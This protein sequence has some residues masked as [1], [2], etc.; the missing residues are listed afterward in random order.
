ML[1][2][3]TMVLANTLE[4]KDVS[5]GQHSQRLVAMA[6][7]TATELGLDGER[8]G[9][10]RLGACLHDIGKVGVPSAILRKVERLSDE[11]FDVVRAHPEIGAT[12]LEGIDT[13]DEVRQ[14]VRHHHERFDGAGYPH[15]LAGEAIPLG[16]RIVCVVDSFDVMREGRPYSPPRSLDEVITELHAHSGAQFDPDILAAFLQMLERDGAV[17]PVGVAGE[18]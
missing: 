1:E 8:R 13:W 10:I 2:H 15:G 5:T 14:I 17:Q 16:A 11:E 12:I 7:K 18:A 6:D 4:T 9:A 3:F